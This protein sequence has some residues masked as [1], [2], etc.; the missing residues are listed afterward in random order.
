[1]FVLREE[2]DACTFE[3]DNNYLLVPIMKGNK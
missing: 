1:M 2:R 3:Y